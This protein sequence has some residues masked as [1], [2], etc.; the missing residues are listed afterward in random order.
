MQMRKYH[1]SE[2]L[3]LIRHNMRHLPD[4]IN[5]GNPDI[6]PELTKDNYSLISRGET[7]REI[8]NYRKELEQEI[9]KYNRKNIVHAISWI[10][11]KPADC[12]VEQETEFFKAAHDFLVST[13][14]MGERCVLVSEVHRDERKY[15]QNGNLLSK[16]HL[17]FVFIPA[18][19][20]TKHEGYKWRLCADQLT[21]R[22]QMHQYHPAFQKYLKERGIKGTVY[23]T[24]KKGQIMLSIEDLK[25]LTDR[26]LIDKE[27]PLTVERLSDLVKDGTISRGQVKKLQKQ[28]DLSE[29]FQLDDAIAFSETQKAVKERDQTIDALQAENA[30][31]RAQRDDFEAR[32]TAVQKELEQQKELKF[33]RSADAEIR[34]GRGLTNPLAELLKKAYERDGTRNITHAR[35]HEYEHDVD[36]DL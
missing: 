30:E 9:F 2:V 8:N 26:G 3:G 12:P 7:C 28:I 22:K 13:L 4:G 11:Q 10:V 5:S 18:V 23:G 15:D 21:R 29:Q 19:P 14:P 25:E 16:D 17:H 35:E 27:N 34:A 36:I 24:K 32:L 20:D 31:I 6:Q 1:N 33:A